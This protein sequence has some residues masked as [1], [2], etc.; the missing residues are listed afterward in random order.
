MREKAEYNE[1]RLG[2]K[3]RMQIGGGV[4]AD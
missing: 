3:R 1:E 2:K 4:V